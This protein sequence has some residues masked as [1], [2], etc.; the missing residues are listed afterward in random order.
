M[1]LTEAKKLLIETMREK[2]SV[3]YVL[4]WLQHSYYYKHDD[5]IEMAVVLKQL[6][7]YGVE[8]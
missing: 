6:K 3:H 8:I 7:E 5:E 2:E 1:T 4:G